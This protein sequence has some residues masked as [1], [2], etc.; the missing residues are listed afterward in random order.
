M[1][2]LVLLRA[3]PF[4][5]DLVLRD[6]DQLA[7]A[8]APQA[9]AQCDAEDEQLDPRE[10]KHRPVTLQGPEERDRKRGDDRTGEERERLTPRQ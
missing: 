10:R 8:S 1:L 4:D 7:I 6:R 3:P 5:D 9:E 2:L